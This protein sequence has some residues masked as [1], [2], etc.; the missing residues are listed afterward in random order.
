MGFPGEF[1]YFTLVY[2][3][4]LVSIIFRIKHKL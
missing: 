1:E 3:N 2:N 4:D